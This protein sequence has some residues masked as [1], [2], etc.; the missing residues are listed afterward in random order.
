MK[1]PLSDHIGVLLHM[2]DLEIV[3]Y[4]K[5]RLSPVQLTPEQH[6]IIALLIRQQGLTQNEIAEALSKDKS[7]MTRMLTSLE[8]KGYVTRNC[9]GDD[10]RAMKVF[11]TEKG[12]SLQDNVE[13]VDQST[14]ALMLRGFSE[15]ECA[16]L[17][18]LLLKLRDNVRDEQRSMSHLDAP[19]G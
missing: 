13:E 18:R 5:E 16:E 2:I 12:M 8:N 9:C 17:A 1:H 15:A 19:E 11:L 6:L 7:S 3:Q 10:R 14:R 4:M